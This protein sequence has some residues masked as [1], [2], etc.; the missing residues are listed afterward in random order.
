MK[1]L[2]KADRRTFVKT[3]AKTLAAGMVFSHLPIF[4]SANVLGQ[5]IIKLG[6]VGCGGRGTGA[7]FQA[8]MASKSV[9]LVAM[10]DVFRHELDNSLQQVSAKFSDQVA[11]PKE[12]QFLGL[13]AFEKVIAECDAVIL[14]TP[15]G[16]RP[17]HFQ[18]AI[19]AGKHVFLE[20]PLAVD[21]PG[22]RKVIETGK[23]A[24]E[25][26]LNVVVGLQFRY[27][28]A[29]NEMVT[30]IH[31]GEIGELLSADVYYNVGKATVH[32]RK[33]GQTELEYQISNWHYFNWLWGGQLAGQAIHQIDVINWIKQGYPIKASGMGGRAMLEGPD[34]G[35]IFDHHYVEFEYAD[36][37]KLHVQCRQMDNCANRMGFNVQGTKAR[38]DE[39]YQFL[40]NQ[41]NALWR[42]R[43]RDDPSSSQIEQDVFIGAILGSKPY[44]NNVEFGAESSM[45]TIMG[46]MA[47]ESGQIIELDKAKASDLSIV[48]DSMSWEMKMG[49]EPLEDGNY[50]IPK[51]GVRVL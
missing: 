23:K 40:D 31:S 26:K 9:Q 36:G 18:H 3:T 37:S 17:Q 10:G 15:P 41:G 51:P 1:E 5:E 47:I 22:Y 35:E 11:V 21:G 50:A 13:D 6:L 44:V 24:A 45:T 16:F 46:R 33:E 30:K 48:P 12:R 42:Y 28:I 29:M 27:E 19:D 14:A 8:L 39:R 38:A 34:H 43:D 49:N 32:P 20:K 7:I 25:K 2:N 4:S